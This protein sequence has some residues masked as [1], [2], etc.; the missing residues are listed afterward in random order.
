MITFIK[1][2]KRRYNYYN[3]DMSIEVSFHYGH[4]K[5]MYEITLSSSKH[6]TIRGYEF[7]TYIDAMDEV[8]GLIGK[9]YRVMDQA[10]LELEQALLEE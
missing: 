5:Y 4:N 9:E 10:D 6:H 1:R 7:D 2:A 3:D 8:C